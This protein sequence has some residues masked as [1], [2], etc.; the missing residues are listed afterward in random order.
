MEMR[1]EPIARKSVRRP[2]A[3]FGITKEEQSQ[4]HGEVPTIYNP[5]T[6]ARNTVFKQPTTLAKMGGDGGA[7]EGG[8]FTSFMNNFSSGV[9]KGLTLGLL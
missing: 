2:T 5:K 4:Q 9:F 8:S 7:L 3:T 1:Y 6:H